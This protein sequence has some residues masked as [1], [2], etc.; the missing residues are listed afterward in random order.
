MTPKSEPCLEPRRSTP[1]FRAKGRKGER[2]GAGRDPER[3]AVTARTEPV[4][5]KEGHT[6]QGQGRAGAGQ[7]NVMDQPI[8]LLSFFAWARGL[9]RWQT[10]A[11]G[12]AQQGKP[13]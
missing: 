5:E 1:A 8:V 13:T 12:Q 11:W 6:N 9:I 4:S 10:S 3:E 2:Q 7:L